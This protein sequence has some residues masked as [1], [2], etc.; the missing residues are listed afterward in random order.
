MAANKW[1]HS[2]VS[3]LQINTDKITSFYFG[4]R[5]PRLY[6]HLVTTSTTTILSATMFSRIRHHLDKSTSTPPKPPTETKPR[7][8]PQGPL[9]NAIYYPNWRVYRQQP[10]SSLRLG[11]VSHV[12]YAFA[13]YYIHPP[14]SLPTVTNE[15]RVREDGTVYV[16]NHTTYNTHIIF[17]SLINQAK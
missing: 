11:C 15:I 14:N 1:Y 17:Q 4:I 5:H 12:F 3:A 7:P 6:F 2:N 9:V 8:K 16:C 13:W 10:P